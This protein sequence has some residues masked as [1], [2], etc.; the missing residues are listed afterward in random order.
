MT[1]DDIRGLIQNKRELV[2]VT[3][4]AIVAL[5]GVLTA[6]KV[7]GF[8]I[9]LAEAENIVKQAVAQ[10][11]SD[12]NVVKTIIAKDNPLVD[13][14]KKNNL[15]APPPPHE[16][17]VKAV[18]GILDNEAYING[19]WYKVGARIG[20]AK[21]VAIDADSVTTEWEGKKKVF[22][23]VDAESSSGPS[24]SKSRSR[25]PTSKSGSTGGKQ[26]DMI[27]IG[28][29]GQPKRTSKTA[30]PDIKKERQSKTVRPGIKNE[31]QISELERA[32]IREKME[33]A[34]GR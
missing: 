21:I 26:A 30:R 5:S 9:N 31:R 23:P 29:E 10:S 33:K 3:L 20:D 13:K 28:S 7:M 2:P 14:L 4:L 8:Y 15:F 11:K 6:T 27:V 17:P 19:K 12:P 32:K 22:Y 24:P 16:N 1:H 25:K 18:P 34:M